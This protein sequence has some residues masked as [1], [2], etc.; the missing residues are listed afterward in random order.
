MLYIDHMLSCIIVTDILFQPCPDVYL[1]PI[2]SVQ[3]CEEL[4]EEAEYDPEK[5]SKG[6]FEVGSWLYSVNSMNKLG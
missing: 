4:I 5:W 1:F 2:A 3:F 6:I